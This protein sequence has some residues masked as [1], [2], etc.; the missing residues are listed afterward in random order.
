[1][2]TVIL[3]ALS[4]SVGSVISVISIS[5]VTFAACPTITN[6]ATF[7]S[8]NLANATT[9]YR[10]EENEGTGEEGGEEGTGEEGRGEGAGEEGRGEG[11]GEEGRGEGVGEGE[12][13]GQE[14]KGEGRWQEK[15][16]KGRG[17]RGRARG[18]A[19][20]EGERRGYTVQSDMCQLKHKSE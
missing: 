8:A 11:V 4:T 12:G 10:K 6:D 13:R 16:G 18:G 17:R 5:D 3:L 14:R 20:E 9:C 19:G 7:I 15:K 2:V 1:M